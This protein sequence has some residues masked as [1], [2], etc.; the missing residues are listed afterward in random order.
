MRGPHKFGADCLD[1]WP[2]QPNIISFNNKRIN[3]NT[4]RTFAKVLSMLSF[5]TPDDL[6]IFNTV[7]RDAFFVGSADPPSGVLSQT[8]IVPDCWMGRTTC[9]HKDVLDRERQPEVIY[10]SSGYLLCCV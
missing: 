7:A 6:A 3:E 4:E 5:G 8:V 2:R 10:L 1:P 9:G